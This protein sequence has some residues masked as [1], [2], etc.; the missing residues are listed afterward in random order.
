MTSVA[1]APQT[2]HELRALARAELWRAPTCGQCPGY[3]QANLVVMPQPEAAFFRDFAATN[4]KPLPV[5]EELPPGSFE[6]NIAPGGDIRTDCPGYR[7][8]RHGVPEPASTL[9]DIWREDMVGFLIGCSF[10]FE[11]AMLAA[12]LPVR[13]IELGLNVPMYRTNRAMRQIGPFSGRIVVT[14]RPIPKD[15]VDLAIAASIR[16]TKAHGAP[17]HIGDPAPLGIADLNQPDYGDPVPVRSGEVP[18]FWACGVSGLEALIAAQLPLAAT[19]APGH[20]FVTD[21]REDALIEKST[22]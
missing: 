16:L 22:T 11:W 9:C 4:S 15:K 2:P 13:H 6:P 17:I 10:S 18:V 20:M 1:P 3:A 5:L 19:H 12:G 21:L 8:F 14:M 7:I